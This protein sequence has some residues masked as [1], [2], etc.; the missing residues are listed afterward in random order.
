[1]P[2]AT[3]FGLNLRLIFSWTETFKRKV[4]YTQT[5]VDFWVGNNVMYTSPCS[6]TSTLKMEAAQP[7]N[8]TTQQPIKT[9]LLFSAMNTSNYAFVLCF[10]VHIVLNAKQRDPSSTLV[11]D[12]A[13]EEQDY[14]GEFNSSGFIQVPYACHDVN[15]LGEHIN[16]NGNTENWSS[17]ETYHMSALRTSVSEINTETDRMKE[18][19]QISKIFPKCSSKYY[20]CW[21]RTHQVRLSKGKVVPVLN[22]HSKKTYPL[23]N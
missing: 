7:P 20:G 4:A 15:L 8:Y 23:L 18:K 12:F 6:R 17:Y 11:W 2:L 19:K 16:T 1:M 3:G 22:S 9:R 14:H 21:G 5:F 10:P 13:R